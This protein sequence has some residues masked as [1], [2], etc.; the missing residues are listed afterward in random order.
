M[1]YVLSQNLFLTLRSSL[2]SPLC[3]TSATTIISSHTMLS[4]AWWY[5]NEMNSFHSADPKTESTKRDLVIAEGCMAAARVAIHF[6]ALL[7]HIDHLFNALRRRNLFIALL[8]RISCLYWRNCE[9]VTRFMMTKTCP[10]LF[11]QYPPVSAFAQHFVENDVCKSS[12]PISNVVAL[13]VDFFLI[14]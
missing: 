6:K 1:L 14:G 9:V 4:K 3:L 8:L 7:S 10:F 13:L 12:P 2:N 11:T 5:G